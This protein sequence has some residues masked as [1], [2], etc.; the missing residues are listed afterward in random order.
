MSWPN[1]IHDLVIKTFD[2]KNRGAYGQIST[3]SQENRP[4]VRTVHIHAVTNPEFMLVISTNI[5]SQKW[6]S[7]KH[8]PWIAGCYWDA[9]KQ[10]QFRFEGKTD[11]VTENHPTYSD[12]VDMMW[13]RTRAEV[14]TAY[15]LDDKGIDLQTE[16]PNVDPEQHSINHG[17]II[18]HPTRWDIFYNDSQVYRF[19]K[20]FI[21][22]R[23]GNSWT[24]RKVHSLHEQT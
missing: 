7:L 20:R 10:I 22:D 6:I 8:N 23:T 14:R 12:L 16:N 5:Q 11:L 17:V 1:E 4:S 24:V 19:G 15:L 21:Y 18:I 2:D 9:E 3:V 13:K